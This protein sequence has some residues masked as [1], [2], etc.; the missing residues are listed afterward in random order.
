MSSPGETAVLRGMH[1]FLACLCHGQKPELVHFELI[2]PK[3]GDFGALITIGKPAGTR[4]CC[5]RTCQRNILHVLALSF[6][7]FVFYSVKFERLL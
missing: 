5:R 4:K 7:L 3:P 2:P 1:F 6:G